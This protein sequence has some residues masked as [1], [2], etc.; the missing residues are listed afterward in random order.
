M[1]ASTIK[2][3]IVPAPTLKLK[4]SPRLQN[5]RMLPRYPASISGGNAIDVTDTSGA[6]TVALDLLKI[7][8]V[9]S[10]DPAAE[11]VVLVDA[12]GNYELVTVSTLLNNT[13]ETVQVITAAGDIDV[14]V[15][16]TLLIMNRAVDQSP[17]NIILPLASAKIGG[18]KIVDWK[19]NS[20]AF[21][22]TIKTT[23]PDVF[24][25]ALTQWTL[26]GA[27]ASLKLDPYPGLGYAV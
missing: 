6:L 14:D 19:G 15:K 13:A 26:D 21:P 23:A 16:T 4:V 3:R 7:G 2:L 20:D 9:G 8:S 17:S 22:H 11:Y 1:T 18:V 25:G 10:F 27:G 12:N 24:Q 5:V